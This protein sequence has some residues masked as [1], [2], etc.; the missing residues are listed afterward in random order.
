MAEPNLTY[1][2][3]CIQEI[4]EPW[5]VSTSATDLV[6][7]Q[8]VHAFVAHVDQE[9]R[10]LRP[11]GRAEPTEHTRA[12]Y[13]VVPMRFGSSK[14]RHV[15]P[16]AGMMTHPGERWV[17]QRGKVR[18]G[19]LV[20]LGGTAPDPEL[21][22]GAAHILA[23]VTREEHTGNVPSIDSTLE[24]VSS[25]RIAAH[26]IDIHRIN[27][28]EED[29]DIAAQRAEG[30]TCV[31]GSSNAGCS[32]CGSMCPLKGRDFAGELNAPNDGGR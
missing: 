22:R 13:E 4:C 5:W 12:D 31:A 10:E 1:P 24:A 29:A 6:R 2:D 17:L 18:P 25:A 20:S 21:R 32:R 7:G 15:L 16:V 23:A 28:T 14:P 11:L 30:C 9:A 19:I 27:A 26:V 3:H 8:L